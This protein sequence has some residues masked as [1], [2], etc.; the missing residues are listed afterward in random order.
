VKA[1]LARIGG[2]LLL[3][4]SFRAAA[5]EAGPLGAGTTDVRRSTSIDVAPD[6]SAPERRAPERV[7]S[8]AL[9]SDELLL[10]TLPL[11][12]WVGV[13]Y[14][15]DWP[16]A[17]PSAG[18]F[19]ESLPRTLGTTEDILSHR[20]DLVIV[21]PYSDAL[22]VAQLKRAGVPLHLVAAPSAFED[23]FAAWAVLGDRVGQRQAARKAIERA[24]SKLEQIRVRGR[25][26]Q[27][28][29]VAQRRTLLVQGMFSYG[30]G[31]LQHDCLLRAGLV[32][33]LSRQDSGE[34][35]ALN[36]EYVLGLAPQIIFVAANVRA[37]RQAV[38]SDLPPGVPWQAV[39]AVQRRR[40]VAVPGAWMASISHHA[41]LACE[42]YATA[43]SRWV[44]P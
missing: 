21:S 30:P 3:A 33:V 20:P 34:S 27:R 18:R 10:E 2:L 40:V 28:L 13:S 29:P 44:E 23:L 12:H 19:P 32:N 8:A 17:T 5:E 39:P 22:S 41:L 9:L 14:V 38:P 15:V 6:N 25:R 11:E 35:P 42:A 26:A 31:S 24:R 4:G 16:S 36:V 7:L 1:W 37:P 43:V